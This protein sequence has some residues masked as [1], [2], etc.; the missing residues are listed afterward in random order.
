[1]SL[2]G[3]KIINDPEV[4][5]VSMFES[6]EGDCNVLHNKATSNLS[7]ALMEQGINL[8]KQD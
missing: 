4:G 5:G 3:L 2:P 6:Q 1:M 8:F 7:T